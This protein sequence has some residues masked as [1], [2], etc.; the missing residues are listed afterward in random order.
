VITHMEAE[1]D[2]ESVHARKH[3]TGLPS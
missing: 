2:H 3:Y 1:E